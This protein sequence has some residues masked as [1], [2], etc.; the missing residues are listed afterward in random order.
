M[1][2]RW[3][4]EKQDELYS[5]KQCRR[6]VCLLLLLLLLLNLKLSCWALVW[7][8]I[9]S[10]Y[11]WSL[12][13]WASFDTNSRDAHSAH[14][15]NHFLFPSFLGIIPPGDKTLLNF[16]SYF[17]GLISISG[18]HAR[19]QTPLSLLESDWT[20][21]LTSADQYLISFSAAKSIF[22]C[23]LQ[24]FLMSI[25]LKIELTRCMTTGSGMYRP[26]FL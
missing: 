7:F 3:C 20:W 1:P 15:N 8:D 22:C 18:W 14:I 12:D 21:A 6:Q 11:C 16:P 5:L 23:N 13:G 19:G 9:I 24:F 25:S 26:G 2:D 17:C 10:H 4:R